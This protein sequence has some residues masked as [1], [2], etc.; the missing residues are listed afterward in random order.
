MSRPWKVLCGLAAVCVVV[1]LAGAG[2]VQA[3]SAHDA[4]AA[5]GLPA[6]F[7]FLLKWGSHGSGDGQFYRPEG[8]TTDAAGNLA[9][10]SLSALGFAS[11]ADIASINSQLAGI[12]ARLNDLDGV[13]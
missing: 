5:S 13:A 12:N 8:I 6:S 2:G 3:K 7:G 9:S 11:P 4:R 10:T 1:A